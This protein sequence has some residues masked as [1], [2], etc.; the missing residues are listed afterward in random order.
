MENTNNTS[1]TNN[2][3][4]E[5]VGAPVPSTVAPDTQPVPVNPGMPLQPA[6]TALKDRLKKPNIN[7]PK[8]KLNKKTKIALVAVPAFIVTLLVVLSV[9]KSVGGG[10][11]IALPIPSE[12][13]TPSPEPSSSPS[14]Y[15]DDDGVKMIEEEISAYEQKLNESTFRDDTLRIPALDWQVSFK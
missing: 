13:S 14:P 2:P 1:D 7:I 9:I 8:I 5:P 6:P 11:D 10:V 3:L 15:Q 12:S 4:V